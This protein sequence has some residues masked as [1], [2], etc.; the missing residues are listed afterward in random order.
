MD[1]LTNQA[2]QCDNFRRILKKS[3]A[4]PRLQIGSESQIFWLVWKAEYPNKLLQIFALETDHSTSGEMGVYRTILGLNSIHHS[5]DLVVP[6]DSQAIL[7]KC[8]NDLKVKTPPASM[9][10][11]VIAKYLAGVL[12][13]PVSRLP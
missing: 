4:C 10:Y 6:F 7:K 12:H 1:M 13:L 11:E 8:T 2:E 5:A 3:R 9:L